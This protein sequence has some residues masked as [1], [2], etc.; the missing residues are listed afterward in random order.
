MNIKPDPTGTHQSRPPVFAGVDT[1][2]DV[3]VAAVVD[4]TGT[5]L[6]TGSFATTRAGYR[7]SEDVYRLYRIS[8][9]SASSPS[10]APDEVFFRCGSDAANGVWVSSAREVRGGS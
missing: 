9:V 3:H 5:M 1:H 2:K 10:G 7:D 6:G 4:A 8:D